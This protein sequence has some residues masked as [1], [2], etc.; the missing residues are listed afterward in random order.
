ML[1][2]D[3]CAVWESLTTSSMCCGIDFTVFQF[4][5]GSSLSCAFLAYKSVHGLASLSSVG[6]CRQLMPD[7]DSVLGLD[8]T[9][10]FPL[11]FGNLA[12]GK[13]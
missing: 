1:L 11:P 12:F 4:N 10:L 3:F 6:L 2:D 8:L 7:A 5:N 13:H 9:L